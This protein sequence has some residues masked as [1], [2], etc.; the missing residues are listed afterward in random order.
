MK[1]SVSATANRFREKG[2]KVSETWI[3][4]LFDRGDIQGEMSALGRLID[5]KSVDLYIKNK[6][7]NDRLAE[8][9]RRDRAARK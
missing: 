5:P 3:R 2:L 6:I 1:L 4:I 9:E 7:E 8:Q